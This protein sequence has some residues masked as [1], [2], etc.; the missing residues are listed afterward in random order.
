MVVHNVSG[1]LL[2]NFVFPTSYNNKLTPLK[3]ER[4]WWLLLSTSFSLRIIIS[5]LAWTVSVYNKLFIFS[6]NDPNFITT[7][8]V[9][10]P[11]PTKELQI[12]R[13]QQ[14]GNC[15]VY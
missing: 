6:Q 7:L 9:M 5:G 10:L 15:P 13:E 14:Q 12:M 8:G 2:A 3:L 1:V 4:D 11:P